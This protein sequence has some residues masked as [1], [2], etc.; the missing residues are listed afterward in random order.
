M[1]WWKD[2]IIYQI[3]PRSFQDSNG[4]GIGDIPGI[5]SRLDHL[6]ELGVDAVWLSPVYCSPGDDRG[7]DISDYCGINPEFG[8]M[9][10]MDRLIEEAKRRGIRIIMDL[11]INHTSTAHSWFE[12]SRRRVAPYT[13]YY[14]WADKPNNWTGFFGEDCWV[15]D[16]V[17]GQYY[18]HLFAKTQADLNYHCPQVLEEVKEILHFWLKKGVAGFRCDVINILYKDSLESSKK[19]LILTG[20]EHYLSLEGTHQ[21][22]RELR[23]VLDEYDAFTVGETVFVT[24]KLAHDLCDADR[25]ELNMVF[26]FQ[27]MECDQY[28]LKWFKRKFRPKVFMDCLVKWQRE[29]PW[30]TI[31]LENHDQPRSI[32]RFGS[33]KYWKESG[34]LL[35]TLLLTLR[36]T[37]FIYEGQEFGMMDFDFTKLSQLDDVESHNVD[38]VLQKLHVPQ[39]TRWKIIRRTSRDNARTPVQWDATPNAG[40]TTGTPWLGVNKNYKEINLAVQK[41]DPDSIWS[42]YKEMIAMRRSSDVLRMGEFIPLETGSQVFAYRRRLRD[43]QL[44]VVLNFSNDP[45]HCVQSGTLIRSNYPTRRQFSGMLAPWEAVILG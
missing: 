38:R 10:D 23:K 20:S 3:Y 25:K 4:D 11:V 8:T 42:W 16:E 18:L 21:I 45:A 39:G 27:H 17:R 5:I 7:Y 1:E 2:A 24:P 6:Q 31:Y 35:A 15:Y 40:F 13:D 36:G 41:D 33:E 34:K 12:K 29:L 32:P 22:L 14:Y 43:K 9:E 26:S 28:F 44:T 37:P 19:S 30:N